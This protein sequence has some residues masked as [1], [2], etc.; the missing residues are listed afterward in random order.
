[1]AKKLRSLS[2]SGKV[3]YSD[4]APTSLPKCVFDH[5]IFSE[6]LC[7]FTRLP[8]QCCTPESLSKNTGKSVCLVFESWR[9]PNRC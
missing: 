8:T 1:M 7:S 3:V 9:D 2:T 6:E 5:G 4:S